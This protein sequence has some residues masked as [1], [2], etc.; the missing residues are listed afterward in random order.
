MNPI[1]EKGASYTA[2]FNEVIVAMLHLHVTHSLHSL[3]EKH[4]GPEPFV[5][6]RGGYGPLS[7]IS[8]STTFNRL[9]ACLNL[10]PTFNLDGGN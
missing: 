9:A 5:F 2:N 3:C 8:Y 6:L 1:I 10:L 7:P 4:K